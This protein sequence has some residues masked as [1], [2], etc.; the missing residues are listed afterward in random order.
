MHTAYAL[1]R[2]PVAVDQKA[3]NASM[4]GRE[5]IHDIHQRPGTRIHP[6]SL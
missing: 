6:D 5:E 1:A 3:G 2:T 4:Y